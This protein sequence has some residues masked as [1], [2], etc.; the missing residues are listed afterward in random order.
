MWL[1][2]RQS[3]QCAP[4]AMAA[5]A[6]PAVPT[7]P[8]AGLAGLAGPGRPQVRVQRPVYEQAELER[9]FGF[10]RRQR[11]GKPARWSAAR[12]GPW[13]GRCLPA[14]VP[15]LA[16]L[17]HYDWRRDLPGDLAAGATVAVMHVPQVGQ[18]MELGVKVT[19]GCVVKYCINYVS[20]HVKKRT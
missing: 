19:L 2:G 14:R 11:E 12:L 5:T 15:P 4:S 7:A 13:L 16:W 9:A 10:G 1:L 6:G 17:R 18:C 8:P 20:L 3:A